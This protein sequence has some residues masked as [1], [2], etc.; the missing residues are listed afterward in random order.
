M[1]SEPLAPYWI[2]RITDGRIINT[3]ASK[4][5]LDC[6]RSYGLVQITWPRAAPTARRCRA[7]S[8]ARGRRWEVCQPHLN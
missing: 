5:L 2:R 4:W 8:G 3:D 7:V 1:Q 6:V